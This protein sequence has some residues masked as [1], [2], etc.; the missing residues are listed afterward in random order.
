MAAGAS[1]TLLLLTI[2]LCLST[3]NALY[4]PVDGRR[5]ALAL[6]APRSARAALLL[7]HAPL[8]PAPFLARDS[9][10]PHA[11]LLA[12]D[13]K[14]VNTTAGLQVVDG[15]GN[16]VAQGS[17]SDGGGS[18]RDVPAIIWMG[19]T[20][21]V[22][23]P[24]LLA[25]IRGWRL[26]TGAG[27]GVSAA[28]LSWAA[29][30][31]TLN[32]QGLPDLVLTAIV[33]GFF[34]FGFVLG[35]F[36]FARGAAIGLIGMAGGLAFGVRIAIIKE[37]LLFPVDSLYAINW[38]VAAIFGAVGGLLV[39]WK[40]R[41]GLLLGCA[42]IGSFLTGLGVDLILNKQDGIGRGLILLFDRNSS[43]LVDLADGYHP[44]LQTRI[45]IYASLGATPVMAFAQH[46]IFRHPFSR[47]SEPDDSA[48]QVDYRDS[49][50]EKWRMTTGS[51]LHSLWDGSGS[52]NANP[53]RFTVN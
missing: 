39:I 31:N 27:I 47:K 4:I 24:L 15:E 36:N 18:G 11:P 28:V 17:A 12:R 41:M 21:A 29:F 9:L 38:V 16:T 33:G 51:W 34:L 7:A 35:L 52:K 22:G 46:R 13:A 48:L 37:G 10:V 44:T 49:V 23:V 42:S 1:L 45:I 5:P 26:T 19:G 14:V 6:A 20:L 3:V 2:I 32:E 8:V 30:I 25:G 40:Q 50:V 53:N 43:H